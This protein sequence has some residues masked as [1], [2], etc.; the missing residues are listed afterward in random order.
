MALRVGTHIF[1]LPRGTESLERGKSSQQPQLLELASADY[2]ETK[3]KDDK[4]S[5]I[6]AD[7]IR[8]DSV[9]ETS[10]PFGKLESN[11]LPTLFDT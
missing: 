7:S 3:A 9:D 5:S 4:L 1:S 11:S 8:L 6:R 2:E 10:L